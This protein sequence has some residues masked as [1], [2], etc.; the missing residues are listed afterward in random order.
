MTDL[1]PPAQW[2]PKLNSDQTVVADCWTTPAGYTVALCRLKAMPVTV[3]RAGEAIPFAYV[4]TF[5]EVPV[6]IAADLHASMPA[7]FKRAFDSLNQM[8]FVVGGFDV[9]ENRY[10]SE[11][12]KC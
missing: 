8:P 12:F 5:E 3:I 4:Q 6:L 10:E 1:R 7:A 9:A 2:K 11:V